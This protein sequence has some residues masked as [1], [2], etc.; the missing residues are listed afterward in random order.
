[1]PH[2]TADSVF[3]E[4]PY[5]LTNTARCVRGDG[6]QRVERAFAFAYE[7]LAAGAT[8]ADIGVNV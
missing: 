2:H 3:V 7:R 5:E 1:M 6:V 4:E 8:L